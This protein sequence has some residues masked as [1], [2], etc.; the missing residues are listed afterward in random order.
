[1]FMEPIRHTK[2]KDMNDV[3]MFSF[4]T[5]NQTTPLVTCQNNGQIAYSDEHG[6]IY[7][8]PY[9]SEIPSILK[10]A[11]YKEKEFK[12]PFSGNEKRPAIYF[13]LQKIANEENQ[14]ETY[15]MCHEIEQRKG[16]KPVET[17]QGLRITEI[18]KTEYIEE[19]KYTVYDMVQVFVPEG[20]EKNVGTYI[21]IN[22]KTVMVCDEFGRTYLI[23][24][25]T[26]IN[27]FVNLLIEAGYTRNPHPEYFLVYNPN[28]NWQDEHDETSE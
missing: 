12:V 27:D 1:M 19:I 8:T 2:L 24:V 22:K 28:S 10:D 9:R 17:T 5:D 23:M 13:W 26:I 6:T 16:I 3:D 7:V 11:G 21:V 18:T 4:M 14:N 20:D 15:E 25:K